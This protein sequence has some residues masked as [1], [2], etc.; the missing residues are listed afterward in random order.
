VPELVLLTV[1]FQIGDEISCE[2]D[3]GDNITGR[4][5]GLNNAIGKPDFPNGSIG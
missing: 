2:T 4:E 5:S 3:R 1:T